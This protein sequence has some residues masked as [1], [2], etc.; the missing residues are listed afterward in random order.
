MTFGG[1]FAEG[2]ASGEIERAVDPVGFRGAS[3]ECLRGG[4]RGEIKGEE[5]EMLKGWLRG[6]YGGHPIFGIEMALKGWFKKGK[7]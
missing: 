3:S 2:G 4:L 7:G 6:T 5:K 1:G